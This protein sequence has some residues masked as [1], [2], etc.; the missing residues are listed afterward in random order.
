M[1]VVI[2][3][4]KYFFF[5]LTVVIVIYLGVDASLSRIILN[6]DSNVK[7]VFTIYLKTNGVHTDVVLPVRSSVFN[8]SSFIPDADS[9]FQWVAFGWGNKE[10]YLNTPEWKDL[11][12]DV[13]ISA[14]TGIG[15]AAIHSTA[16]KSIRLSENCISISLD[17]DSYRHL[18]EYI[19]NY[20]LL[21]SNGNAIRLTTPTFYSKNEY[22]FEAS[23]RYSLLNTCNTWANNAL[24]SC[25]SR[26]CLWTA[27]DKGIFRIYR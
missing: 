11:K 20:I 5:G 16:Y 25:H 8:W 21:D 22:F 17:S 15:D 13:A 18:V 10:F 12:W 23:G 2:K 14:A 19:L 7:G 9:T 1:S 27:F 6:R 24:K 26:A 3:F 4:L